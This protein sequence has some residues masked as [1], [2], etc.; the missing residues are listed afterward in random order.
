[1]RML[2]VVLA[3]LVVSGCAAAGPGGAKCWGIGGK[4]VTWTR[5][6]DGAV[7]ATAKEDPGHAYEVGA[8]VAAL[9][10]TGALAP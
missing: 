5:T 6:A 10:A 3:A 2:M 7:T 9:L 1:M 4:S 8:G